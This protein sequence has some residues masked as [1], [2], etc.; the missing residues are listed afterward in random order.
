MRARSC[1]GVLVTVA[2][3]LLS[4]LSTASPAMAAGDDY[5]YKGATN[6][7]GQF[8][9]YSWCI[10]ENGDGSFQAAEQYSPWGASYRNCTDF[11]IWRLRNTNGVDFS[12]N[13]RGVQ[14]GNANH[15]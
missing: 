14:W 1:C 5:P 7:A 8:G 11:G 12:N 9:T 2:A 6:C 4:L 15:W 13:Y 10:D 3:L